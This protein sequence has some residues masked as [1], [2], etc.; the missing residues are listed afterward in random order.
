MERG[1]AQ[2]KKKAGNTGAAWEGA[3]LYGSRA[4][5]IRGSGFDLSEFALPKAVS[6]QYLL[7]MSAVLQIDFPKVES[8]AKTSLELSRSVIE[9]GIQ[10][11]DWGTQTQSPQVS[12]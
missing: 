8:L 2:P 6:T 4:Q 5:N 10:R 9:E 12:K 3:V 7:T 1:R 11:K